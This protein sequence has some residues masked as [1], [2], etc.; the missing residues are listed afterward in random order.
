MVIIDT[1]VWIDYMNGVDNAQ[2]DWLD[3]RLGVVPFALTDLALCEVLQ[4]VQN[5]SELAR[6]MRDLSRF[7]VFATG[8]EQMAIAS[9]RNY[10]LLRARGI[11]VRKTID[12][13]IATFCIEEGVPLLHRDRDFEGFERYLGLRAAYSAQ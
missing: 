1:T 7:P 8:G 4:G 3:Q 13:I 6:F 12:C 10:R 2:T 9:A 5:E 11:T